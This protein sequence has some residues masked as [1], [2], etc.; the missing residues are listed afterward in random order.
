MKIKTFR[1]RIDDTNLQKDEQLI[2]RFMESVTVKKTATEF[3]SDKE[4]CWSILVYYEDGIN[5]KKDSIM[6][7][8]SEKIS[9]PVDTPL[10]NEE[11]TILSG[12]KLWRHD[13]SIK[14]SMPSYMICHNSELITIAKTK[15]KNL[16]DLAKVKGFSSQ[17]ILKYGDD[18]LA[19]LN[20]V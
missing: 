7:A 10:N 4:N 9:F 2:N 19:L 14:T 1:I 17:K 20:S 5:V 15:P 13:M 18:V 11:T 6:S 8:P 16:V 12:L 3:I